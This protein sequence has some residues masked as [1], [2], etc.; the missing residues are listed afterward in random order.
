VLFR[1]NTHTMYKEDTKYRL[2]TDS[3][4]KGNTWADQDT[5]KHKQF[6]HTAV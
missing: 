2:H 1:V 5:S 3:H 6:V 4:K